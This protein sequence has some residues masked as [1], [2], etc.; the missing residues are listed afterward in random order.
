MN[1][2]NPP[3]VITKNPL[4]AL[5]F[6]VVKRCLLKRDQR[7][8]K[9]ASTPRGYWPEPA[10]R[11]R[12][13]GHSTPAA[14]RDHYPVMGMGIL[15]IVI[16]AAG[17]FAGPFLRHSFEMR[18]E[19]NYREMAGSLFLGLLPFGVASLLWSAVGDSTMTA[20]NWLLGVFGAAIGA[21]LFIY[22]GYVARDL[23]TPP[24]KPPVNHDGSATSNSLGNVT[25]NQ[26]IVTQGQRG[27]NAMDSK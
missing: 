3:T 23:W 1:I 25:G 20:Q 27:D 12:E 11:K 22:G 7:G 21:S 16:P 19:G 14:P 4:P 9:G 26:G 18:K 8:W 13:T 6:D 17:V 2:V 24:E 10:T 5:K 15:I